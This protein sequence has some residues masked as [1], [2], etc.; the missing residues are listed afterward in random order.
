M[1]VEE[2]CLLGLRDLS[3]DIEEFD[4]GWEVRLRENL[5]EVWVKLKA[6]RAEGDRDRDIG[7][8]VLLEGL[9]F[10]VDIDGVT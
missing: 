10:I 9:R 6:E 7:G 1:V 4:L 3:E 2:E 8:F 5:E